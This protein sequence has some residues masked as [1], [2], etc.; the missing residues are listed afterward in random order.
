MLNLFLAKTSTKVG[1]KKVVNFCRDRTPS[2]FLNTP[3]F[4]HYYCRRL[5]YFVYLQNCGGG[6]VRYPFIALENCELTTY[7]YSRWPPKALREVFCKKNSVG[8]VQQKGLRHTQHTQQGSTFHQTSS[9]VR[10]CS[11]RY[12]TGYSQR[13]RPFL[14]ATLF[15]VFFSNTPRC[16]LDG[17]G[18]YLGTAIVMSSDFSESYI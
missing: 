9:A 12:N 15:E 17:F 8:G 5:Q 13:H 2:E 4:S 3:S 1:G 14:N 6:F 16:R 10:K 11:A 18:C 7:L